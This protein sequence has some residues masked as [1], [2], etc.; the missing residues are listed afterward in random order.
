MTPPYLSLMVFHAHH[1]ETFLVTFQSE[2]PL[3][4][5]LLHGMTSLLT[6]LIENFVSKSHIRMQMDLL[7]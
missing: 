2:K 1:C 3:I 7:K 4:L 5:M 6:N